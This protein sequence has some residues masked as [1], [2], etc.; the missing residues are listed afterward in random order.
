MKKIKGKF[1]HRPSFSHSKTFSGKNGHFS[2]ILKVQYTFTKTVNGKSINWT[3]TGLPSGDKTFSREKNH[4]SVILK[5]QYTF[6][7]TNNG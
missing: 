6:T 3:P 5:V 7:K 2:V 1:D 4:R